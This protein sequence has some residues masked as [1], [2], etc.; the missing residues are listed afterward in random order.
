MHNRK[1]PRACSQQAGGVA[2][3]QGVIDMTD[4]IRTAFAAWWRRNIVASDPAPAYSRL[5]RA[6]GLASEVLRAQRERV[7]HGHR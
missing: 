5:D 6:D 3:Q 1:D 7:L 2:D 4:R